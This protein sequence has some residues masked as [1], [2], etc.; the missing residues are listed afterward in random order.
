MSTC[1]GAERASKFCPDC[2]K[3]IDASPALTLLDHLNGRVRT[4]EKDCD[5]ERARLRKFE[6]D[7][8]LDQNDQKARVKRNDELLAKWSAWRD[9]VQEKLVTNVAS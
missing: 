8:S 6:I 4:I 1:C 5:R 7:P 2:G 3:R 9:W